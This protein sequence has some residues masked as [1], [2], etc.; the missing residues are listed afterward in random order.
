MWEGEAMNLIT[1]K[2]VAWQYFCILAITAGMFLLIGISLA[3]GMRIGLWL[4]NWM[5]W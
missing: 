4:T 2:D 5:G 1:F 3:V